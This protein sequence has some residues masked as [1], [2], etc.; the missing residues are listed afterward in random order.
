VNMSPYRLSKD[1]PWRIEKVARP[2]GLVPGR[3]ERLRVAPC[4][5]TAAAQP[6]REARWRARQDSNLRPPA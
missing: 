3:D 1:C 6:T 2:A 4:L 5:R